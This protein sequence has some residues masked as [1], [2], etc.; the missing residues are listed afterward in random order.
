MLL[1]R[2]AP[3]CCCRRPEELSPGSHLHP[4]L[5]ARRSRAEG[6]LPAP[7]MHPQSDFFTCFM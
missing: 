6:V 5:T 2:R 1:A 7:G 3:D 4:G